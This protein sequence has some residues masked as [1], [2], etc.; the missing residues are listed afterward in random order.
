MPEHTHYVEPYFGGGAVLLAKDPEGTSEVVNDLHRV[1]TNFWRVLQ[2]REAF[3]EFLRLCQATPF[4]G[5]E[6]EDARQAL[7]DDP[8]GARGDPVLWAWR[9]FVLCRQSLAGRMT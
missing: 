3:P 7:Q 6:W 4:S 8:E 9:F 2:S 5:I 1:L